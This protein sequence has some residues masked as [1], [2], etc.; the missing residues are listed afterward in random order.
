M[1]ET[2]GITYDK[3]FKTLLLCVLQNLLP[4]QSDFNA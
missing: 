4:Q 3:K 2:I 1:L